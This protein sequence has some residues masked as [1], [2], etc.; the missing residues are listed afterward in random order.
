MDST[1]LGEIRKMKTHVHT[2]KGESTSAIT[3]WHYIP[4]LHFVVIVSEK[5]CEILNKALKELGFFFK[6]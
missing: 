2:K 4:E 6:V 3:D 1:K 5:W